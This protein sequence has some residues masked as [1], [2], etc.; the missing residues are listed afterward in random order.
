MSRDLVII[1]C[2]PI[3]DYPEAPKDQSHCEP[4]DCPKCNN[5]MWLSEKKKAFLELSSN[6][7]KEIWL[8]CY[9]CLMKRVIEDPEYFRDHVRVDI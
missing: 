3:S 4:F 9:T 7:D 6:R 2:P 1:I 8:V 5:K